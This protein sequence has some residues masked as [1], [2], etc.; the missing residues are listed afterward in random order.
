MNNFVQNQYAGQR[1]AR[2][3]VWLTAHGSNEIASVSTGVNPPD[4]SNANPY[5]QILEGTV[6]SK[7]E[8]LGLHFPMAADASQAIVTTANE[9]TVSDVLQ[10]QIGQL[11]ELPVAVASDADRFRL[12]TAI[13]YDLS[14]I[15]LDGA[16]FSLAAGDL[17]EVDSGRSYATSVGA[18]TASVTLVV[19]DGTIFEV[20]DTVEL[21]GDTSRTI[22]AIAGDTL[23]LSAVATL[24]DGARVVS[25][26]DGLYKIT[27]KTVTI[28]ETD[29]L[30]QNVLLPCRPHGKV[31]EIVVIGLTATAKAALVGLI[32]FSQRTIA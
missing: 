3:A 10:F 17:L 32:I 13:D 8:D 21:A 31:K 22:D 26:S 15:T 23:T 12:I 14:T 2:G 19:A 6:L 16:S 25:E 18:V 24:A 20:G 9:I 30:P 4:G 5:R 29:F 1:E 27:N 7:R 28:D 11:V